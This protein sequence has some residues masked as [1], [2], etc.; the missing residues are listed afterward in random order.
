MSRK[1]TSLIAT[2]ALAIALSGAAFAA[3]NVWLR[4]ITVKTDN[5]TA[6]M[7]ELDKGRAMLKKLGIQTQIRIWRATFAGNDAGALVVSQEF[8]SWTAFAEA[9]TKIAG[10]AE[11]QAWLKNLDK[12]RTI[13]S[14]S[15]YR[16][17]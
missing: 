3:S 8:P 5:L 9:Q 10:N 16:E 2:A 1:I 11:F 6:Y 15:L 12:L 14:D 7:Q 4:V 17:L 13:T